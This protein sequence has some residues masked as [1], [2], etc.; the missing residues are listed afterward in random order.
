LNSPWGGIACD[1]E[2]D[3]LYIADS[4]NNRIQVYNLKSGTY[5]R[6]I[7]SVRGALDRPISLAINNDT[8]FILESSNRISI[9][10]R[11]N[12]LRLG[13]SGEWT[14]EKDFNFGDV[15]HLCIFNNELF[16]TDTDNKIVKVFQ[17]TNATISFLRKFGAKEMKAPTGICVNQ[18]YVYVADRDH[19]KILVYNR[20]NSELIRTWGTTGDRNGEL[21]GPRGIALAYD[22][23]IIADQNNKR[24]QWFQ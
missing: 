18:N 17:T 7:G 23:L 13:D 11:H 16:V 12:G 1:S 10:N 2:R 9:W 8:I 5:T 3:E 21:D 20:E 14:G 22:K 19:N 24:V 15:S 6:T 4:E